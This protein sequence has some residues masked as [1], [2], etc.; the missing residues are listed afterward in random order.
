MADKALT[1][2]SIGITRLTSSALAYI[3]GLET[4]DKQVRRLPFNI[5]FD[6]SKNPIEHVIEKLLNCLYS[7]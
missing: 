1:L 4:T 6:Y 7:I 2:V 5:L 3:V